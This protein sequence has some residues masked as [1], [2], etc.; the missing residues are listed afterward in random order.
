MR[1]LVFQHARVEHPA[2]FRALIEGAGH[3]WH[4]VHLDEGEPVP[5]L[6]AMSE[7][8][9]L[10]VMGGPMDVW[11]EDEHP[12]LIPEKAFVAEA[13]KRK[14]PFFGLCFGHQ[15]L[16]EALGGKCGP[17]TPEV[18]IMDVGLTDD[19]RASPFLVGMS[20]PIVSL[21]WHG[22][23]VKEVPATAK[24]LASSPVCPIQAISVGDFAF[25]AQF[26][27]ELEHDTVDNWAAIPAYKAR[28]DKAFGEGG[29]DR[30]RAQCAA[31]MAD[32][33]ADAL[34]IWTNW[35]AATGLAA[36]AA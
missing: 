1:F 3:T 32:F 23:E 30:L 8:D 25:S 13:V 27:M 6:S 18:G 14:M 19:G 15:V 2:A 21:Q 36:R 22:A 34:T 17:G 26:H 9:A 4:P 24:V 7:Y 5:P 10:W 33:N 12:W 20:D 31:K 28:L 35:C 11:D 29:V 16:A